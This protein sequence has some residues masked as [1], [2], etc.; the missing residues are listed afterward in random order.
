MHI[1]KIVHPSKGQINCSTYNNFKHVKRN[2][3][4]TNKSI[5]NDTHHVNPE[6]NTCV[7]YVCVYCIYLM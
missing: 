2:Q 7:L 4:C 3:S 6:S 5:R 1:L